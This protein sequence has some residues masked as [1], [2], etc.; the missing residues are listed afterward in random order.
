MRTFFISRIRLDHL[1]FHVKF[2]ASHTLETLRQKL[3]RTVLA[4]HKQPVPKFPNARQGPGIQNRQW[5]DPNPCRARKPSWWARGPS[6]LSLV[7][8]D[9]MV[10]QSRFMLAT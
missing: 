7:S 1:C 10:S 6:E 3:R 5:V 9:W 4:G 2:A 8:P